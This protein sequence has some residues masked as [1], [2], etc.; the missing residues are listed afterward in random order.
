MR[1]Q[2]VAKA[3]VIAAGLMMAFAAFGPTLQGSGYI[4]ASSITGEITCEQ[5]GSSDC[6]TAII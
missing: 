4:I 6:P 1:K 3:A 2:I 5:G